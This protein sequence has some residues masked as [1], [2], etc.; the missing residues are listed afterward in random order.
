M[1]RLG[2]VVVQRLPHQTCDQ[3]ATAGQSTI[4]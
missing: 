2:G 1:Y 3:E 4:M